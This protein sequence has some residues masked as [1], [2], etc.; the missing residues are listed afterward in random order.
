MYCS[1][2]SGLVYWQTEWLTN[3]LTYSLTKSLT[4]WPS[5]KQTDW[6][7]RFSYVRVSNEKR[8][9]NYDRYIQNIPGLLI[10]LKLIVHNNAC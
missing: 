4:D 6:L 10:V 8:G 2:I 9:T 7:D 1:S 3:S 5:D